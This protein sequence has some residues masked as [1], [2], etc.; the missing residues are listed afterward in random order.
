[1]N[2]IKNEIIERKNRFMA[3]ESE[4][5]NLDKVATA[6]NNIEKWLE[7]TIET[8]VWTSKIPT[9]DEKKALEQLKTE[10]MQFK[11]WIFQYSES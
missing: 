3:L 5:K 8:R 1:L 9:S 2:R 10:V 11:A 4:E 6:A 7:A